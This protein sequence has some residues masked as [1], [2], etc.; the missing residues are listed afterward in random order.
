M[1][2]GRAVR[3][4]QEAAVRQARE[5]L[6]SAFDVRRV[7]DWGW[8]NLDAERRSRGLRIPHEVIVRSCSGSGDEGDARKARCDLSSVPMAGAG[9]LSRL[10]SFPLGYLWLGDRWS[11]SP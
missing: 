4:Q 10:S 2:N 7:S 9:H 8:D 1:D 6:D 11:D 5:R 3:R